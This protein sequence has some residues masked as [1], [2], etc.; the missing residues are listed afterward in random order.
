M[1]FNC[2][3]LAIYKKKI[4]C[5]HIHI[6]KSTIK[7]FNNIHIFLGKYFHK[8]RSKHYHDSFKFLIFLKNFISLI[9]PTDCI[10]F[11]LINRLALVLVFGPESSWSRLKLFYIAT[12]ASSSSMFKHFLRLGALSHE[13]YIITS[14]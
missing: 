10:R 12:R 4:D 7:N 9:Y 3:H 14:P 8:K 6:R 11:F 2:L 1:F 13:S 5:V